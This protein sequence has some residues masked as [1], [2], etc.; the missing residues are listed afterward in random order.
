M[1]LLKD[2][3]PVA[4]AIF[5]ATLF[6]S[7]AEPIAS[8]KVL[9]ATAADINTRR[10]LP[11]IPGLSGFGVETQAGSGRHLKKPRTRIFRIRS[12]SDSGPG[13]LRECINAKEPRTCV[14]EISGEIRLKSILKI[15]HPYITIAGQT[16][17]N[18]GITITQGGFSVET[19][20]VLMQHL[21]VRP[22][23]NHTGVEPRFRDAVSIGAAPP[24]SAYN[25][26]VDHLSLT[27][28]VDENISTAYP[29]THDVTI[30]NCLIAEGLYNSIHPKGPHSKGVMIGDLSKRITLRN[31][32][33]ASNEERNPYIK[34]G[35]SVE[36]I[37]NTVYGWGGRGPWSLCNISN[38]DGTADP[39]SLT[40]I[41]NSY[42]PG[43]WSFVAPPIYASALAISSRIY[44]EDSELKGDLN[45]NRS[46]SLTKLDEETFRAGYPPITSGAFN[47]LPSEAAYSK[48]ISDVGSRPRNRSPID[49]RIISDVTNRSGSL[50]DCV[51]GCLRAGGT[52]RSSPNRT[53]RLR[54][55]R[56]PMSDRN[57]DGYTD[58]ENWLHRLAYRPS[59][60]SLYH[61][62]TSPPSRSSSMRQRLSMNYPPTTRSTLRQ[63][64]SHGNPQRKLL[65]GKA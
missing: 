46:W 33:I 6:N 61:S 14:F 60:F 5:A 34:P 59:R 8:G 16:A 64:T 15:K 17:P 36:M 41:G 57:H 29:N 21:A 65:T 56:S 30:S 19:H 54:L 43:P 28:A 9:S 7:I 51:S 38:N 58:L 47:N 35:A 1:D 52:S 18:P 24:R 26:V 62:S 55:P 20:D 44:I 4:V 53:R 49:Q 3:S 45:S 12:L 39:V 23:D 42:I 40:F 32:L 11:I 37:N 25:V 2:L 27:W 10:D 13:S 22:G 31:N 48:L 50:K 63:R